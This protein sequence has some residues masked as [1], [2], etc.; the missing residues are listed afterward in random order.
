MKIRF[1]V[2]GTSNV[3]TKICV[4]WVICTSY[5]RDDKTREHVM[6]SV[7]GIEGEYRLRPCYRIVHILED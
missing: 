6:R 5:S 2:T 1:V 3:K 4:K 7:P